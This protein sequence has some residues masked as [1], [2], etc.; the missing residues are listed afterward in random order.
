LYDHVKVHARDNGELAIDAPEGRG[1]R[2]RRRFVLDDCGLPLLSDLEQ[3]HAG[4]G[5]E[6]WS[7]REPMA[8][9]GVRMVK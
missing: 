1:R 2:V 3:M 4:A 9:P 5:H 8:A 6:R 7:R